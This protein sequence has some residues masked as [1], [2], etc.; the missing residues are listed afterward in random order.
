MHSQCDS[1][2]VVML[3]E[4]KGVINIAV[5]SAALLYPCA[6]TYSA[7]NLPDCT[8]SRQLMPSYGLE[9]WLGYTA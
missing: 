2:A 9:I 7:Q 1:F 5:C 8:S 3:H 4:T 6:C